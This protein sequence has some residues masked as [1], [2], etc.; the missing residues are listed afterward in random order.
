MRLFAGRAAPIVM[1]DPPDHTAMRR[2]VSRPMTRRQ[3]ARFEP[4]IAAFVAARLDEIADLGDTELDIIG[5]L[6]KPLPSFL[7]AHYLGV[8]PADRRRFGAWTNAIVAA[9]ASGEIATA[10][11]AFA[12]L[13]GY[14]GHL[15][16]RR[17]SQPGDDLVSG[18]LATQ[19][20]GVDE[21]WIVGFVFTMVTGG[22]DTTTGLLGGA[23]DLLTGHRD[24]RQR[25]LGDPAMIRRSVEEFLRLSAGSGRCPSAPHLDPAAMGG[26]RRPGWQLPAAGADGHEHTQVRYL[27]RAEWASAIAANLSCR[28]ASVIA[29]SASLSAF[30]PYSMPHAAVM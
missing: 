12:E 13:F 26:L 25:L 22:N 15:M 24:Q 16:E 6:F 11:Q 1:M 28:S 20:R 9:N 29:R 21:F 19:A 3:V 30:S 8:P 18:L 5:W 7:V 14:A 10:G 23:A 27:P 4:K 2:L 17:R